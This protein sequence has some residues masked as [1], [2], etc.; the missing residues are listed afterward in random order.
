MKCEIC[1]LNDAVLAVNRVVDGVSKE[2]YVCK[3]CARKEAVSPLG[4]ADAMLGQRLADIF[5]RLG[6]AFTPDK[7][8]PE[9]AVCPICGITRAEI[10]EKHRPG[11]PRCFDIFQKELTLYAPYDSLS[12]HAGSTPENGHLLHDIETLER[13]LRKAIVE[14]RFEDACRLTA[15]IHRLREQL[16]QHDA[17]DGEK[18]ADK[19]PK[20]E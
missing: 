7:G 5:I 2:L 3:D 16:G 6:S 10:L 18:P 1:H 4:T 17:G 11:C 8:L 19:E 15:E 13:D 12:D 14:E 20:D 9:N